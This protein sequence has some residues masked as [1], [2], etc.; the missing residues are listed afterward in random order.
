MM[1]TNPAEFA[2][3]ICADHAIIEKLKAELEASRQN[4]QRL[5]AQLSRANDLIEDLQTRLGRYEDDAYSGMV[6]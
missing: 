4:E 3:M 2:P 6:K 5:T 1:F